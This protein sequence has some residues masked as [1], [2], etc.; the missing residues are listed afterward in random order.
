MSFQFDS[1]MAFVMMEIDGRVH[2]PYVW[3]AYAITLL[4]I[5]AIVLNLRLA[6]RR[7]I[8]QQAALLRRRESQLK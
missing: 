3:G 4:G 6:R 1:L 7:F 2:G 5:A 8:K